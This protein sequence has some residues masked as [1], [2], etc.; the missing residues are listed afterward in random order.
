[1]ERLRKRKDVT[2]KESEKRKQPATETNSTVFGSI[3]SRIAAL[4]TG[5]RSRATSVSSNTS[6]AT[7]YQSSKPSA[8]PKL[9]RTAMTDLDEG[10]TR[11]GKFRD[12]IEVDI[13]FIDGKDFTTHVTEKEVH[14]YICKRSLGI[15]RERIHAINMAWRGHPRIIIRLKEKLNI[16]VLPPNF[17]YEKTSTNDDGTTTTHK[18]VCEVVGAGYVQPRP[19]ERPQENPNGPWTRW[20]KIE[21]TGF[22]TNREKIRAVLSAFGTLESHF[23]TETKSFIDDEPQSDDEN[24]EPKEV[25]IATGKLS[26]KMII[27]EPIPQYIPCDGKKLK[28]HYRGIE[29]LCTKCFESGHFRKDCPNTEVHW[30]AYFSLF[31]DAYPN[32]DPD[33]YGR[34]NRL[35]DYWKKSLPPQ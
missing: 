35:A 18:I 12:V 10:G 21:G 13:L 14:K 29:K 1:M 3:T 8:E 11:H 31:K 19:Q 6:S 30:L 7:S 16:D 22:Q 5:A 15:K 32:I 26:I 27:D 33:T 20:V 25:T 34:W 4:T 23:E 2:P 24:D 17:E 9:G 28:V